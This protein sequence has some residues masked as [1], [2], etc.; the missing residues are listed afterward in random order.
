MR[1]L[2]LLI[3]VC[4]FGNLSA[5]DTVNLSTPRQAVRNHLFY[6]Q[7]EQ[8]KPEL[9]AKS[10]SNKKV[11]LENAERTAIQL[12]QIYNGRGYYVNEFS[13]PNDPDY[14]DSI[15]KKHVYVITSTIPEL[16]VVKQGGKWVYSRESINAIPELHSDLYILGLHRLMNAIP[17]SWHAKFLGIDIAQYIGIVIIILLALILHRVLWW[18]IRGVL[19]NLLK[20]L[21]K[22]YVPSGLLQ[23]V[24][25][26]FSW[27]LLIWSIKALVPSLLLPIGVNKYVMLGLNIIQPL[28]GTLV[29]YYLVGLL[30]NF[31]ELRARKTEGKLD[32]QLVPLLSKFL[33]LVVILLGVAYILNGIGI[34][35]TSYLVGISIGGLALA[36]AAQDTLKNLFGSAMIFLDK[37]FQI[38]D[39]VNYNGM[40]GTIEEVGFRS[41]RVRTFYN[42]IITIPNGKIAD[43]HVDNYGMRVY[44][45][46]S[47]KI[48][49]TYDTPPELVEVFVEGLREIVRNHPDTRK[50]YYEVHLNDL[51][52]T[53]LEILF[54]IFFETKDWSGEMRAR[55]EVLI[56]IMKLAERLKVRFAF[57]TQT[58]HIEEMPGQD[59]LTPVFEKDKAEFTA[60]MKDF[61][62]AW[63]ASIETGKG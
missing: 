12:I 5:R 4:F 55:H 45:R 25:K 63:K 48:T 49:I 23:K 14:V 51:G 56:A 2:L 24:A 8:Y 18:L 59:S 47:T 31:F 58:L 40:D 61:I 11:E 20:R 28:F 7:Q 22:Q 37:P 38:G 50:D 21:N 36:L 34:D 32:D 26:P 57:P 62:A 17:E 39:W 13:I 60:D 1:F 30:A 10:L 54:Y 15:S 52:A 3:S 6:L 27:F 35:P 42:S 44:R 46:F 53:A 29:F 41:T 9:S 33:K 16:Y 43:T 19:L